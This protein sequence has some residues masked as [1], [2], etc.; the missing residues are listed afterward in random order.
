[1]PGLIISSNS[2]SLLL[3]Q[4]CLKCV[5]LCSDGFC[6]LKDANQHCR[7]AEHRIFFLKHLQVFTLSV[8]SWTGTADFRDQRRMV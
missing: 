8:G 3:F 4:F 7:V 2:H 6:A 5:C 1:M